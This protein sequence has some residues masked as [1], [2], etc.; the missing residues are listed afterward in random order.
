[1][2]KSLIKLVESNF[3]KIKIN[4]IN[5]EI[6]S[7]NEVFEDE[8][9]DKYELKNEIKKVDN[10]IASD[11]VNLK[12]SAMVKGEEPKNKIERSNFSISTYV[13]KFI[14]FL[15]LMILGF[16]GV[17]T[18]FKKGV[19]KKGKLGFLH[20]HKKTLRHLWPRRR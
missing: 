15:S 13:G 16:Y 11:K 4:K 19:I 5:L 1:M 20:N 8:M 3:E 2:K 9:I 10:Q 6:D 7:L 12:Q 14:A 18:H 17:L